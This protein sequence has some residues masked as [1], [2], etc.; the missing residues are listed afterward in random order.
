MEFVSESNMT[1]QTGCSIRLHMT[2]LTT[3][4][5]VKPL[6]SVVIMHPYVGPTV[7]DI[8]VHDRVVSNTHGSVFAARMQLLL[9]EP[10][11]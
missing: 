8:Y 4:K 5:L 2:N 6:T 7:C 9:V 3:M 11:T 10:T 1:L